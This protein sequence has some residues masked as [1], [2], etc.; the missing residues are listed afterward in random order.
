MPVDDSRAGG[1]EAGQADEG[2]R[3][4]IIEVLLPDINGVLRGKWLPASGAGKLDSD[5]VPMPL[6]LFGLDLWGREVMETELHVETGD[7]DGVCLPVAGTLAPVPWIRDQPTGQVLVS[8][9]EPS[10]KPW[11]LDPRHRL[12]AVVD[13]FAELG[14][15]PVVAFELEF[16]LVTDRTDAAGAPIPFGHRPAGPSRQNMYDM[17]D[18]ETVAPLMRE[19]RAAATAQGILADAVISEAAPGQFEVNLLHRADPMRAADDAVLFRRLVKGIARRH[20]WR[21]TFMPKPYYEFAGSGTH[22]HVSLIDADGRNAFGEVA[23]G[24]ALLASAAA[25][26][27]ASARETALVHVHSHNGFRRLAPGAYAPTTLSWGYDNRSV[28]VRVPNGG[29]KARR[30]EHRIAGADANPYLVLA[31][32]LAGMHAGIVSELVPPP[33]LTGDAYVQ[34]GDRLPTSLREAAEVFAASDFVRVY[35][36][37]EFQRIFALMKLSEAGEF[38]RI[39]SEIEYDAY[40]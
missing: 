13:R 10:G 23:G 15:T 4:E 34:E 35:F 27:L 38:E 16:Y 40:L 3:P 5:G 17:S 30:L 9:H 18:L 2:F 31:A 8:M 20:G 12:Q 33:P 24:D 25:G 29:P 1:A 39:I 21:A 11:Y 32:I 36:G 14:L 37:A 22:V 26:L 19:I 7:V 6:S 28:A